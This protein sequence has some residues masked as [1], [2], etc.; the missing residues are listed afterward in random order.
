M[1]RPLGCLTGAGLIAGLLTALTIGAAAAFGGN[2]LFSPGELNAVAGEAPVGG[3]DSHADLGKDCGQCH[4]PFWGDQHM[5]D[6]CLA[7][8]QEVAAEL[9]VVSGFHYGYAS[10]GNCRDCHT[11]H[12]GPQAELTLQEIVNYPHDRTG[13]ALLAH[14]P[15]GA[16]G[17]FRCMDCHPASLR[18]FSTNSCEGCHRQLDPAYT[19]Q[20][21]S[22]FGSECLD[23]HDGVDRFGIH[24]DHQTLAFPLEGEHLSLEC[25]S[26]HPGARTVQALQ[27][28]P[29][30]CF[31]CHATDDVHSGRLGQVC[32]SCHTPQTWEGAA[33]DHRLTGFPLLGS[34]A[35]ADCLGCHVERQWS[36][37][38]RD[39]TGCHSQQDPHAG[40]FVQDCDACHSPT[41][42]REVLFDHQQ[43]AYPLVG[44][45][46]T[47]SCSGCHANGRYVGTPTACIA[48]HAAE[49]EHDGR[50]GQDCSACHEP[51]TWDE[52]T[53][54]HNLSRFPL[55]GA[56]RS[57]ACLGCHESGSFA[58]TPTAC[59]ACHA[60]P[61][62]HRGV[63]G[64][65]CA[66]C[67]STS[68]WLPASWNGSHSFP[69]NHGGAGGQCSTCHPSSYGQY[70]CYGCHKHEPAKI[71]KKHRE[72]GIDNFSDCARCHPTGKEDGE[73]GGDGGDDD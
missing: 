60:E 41:Q 30:R 32:E 42:W 57:T 31:E 56:H 21:L 25:S 27:R 29:A 18:E 70:T 68:A 1:T 7:C 43:S 33:L 4:A 50:F 14:P 17:A 51:T 5:G 6:R 63:F 53:F 22:D 52:V 19:V 8:H 67:H 61:G 13:F 16:G 38:P 58:G 28:A 11:E 73:G 46:R 49:D 47:A 24:F 2:A 55:T 48:C 10:A 64:T 66:S 15:T 44:A 26:C 54:D 34:H 36:G 37:I 45:H 12:R 65:Q 71:E 69:L 39:C 23:C 72:E 20:H 3:I 9:A 40:Q 59:S 62:I 35:T